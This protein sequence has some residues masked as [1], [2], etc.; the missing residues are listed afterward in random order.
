MEQ[1]FVASKPCSCCICTFLLW[2]WTWIWMKPFVCGFLGVAATKKVLTI[3]FWRGKK[4]SSCGASIRASTKAQ[5]FAWRKTIP[6][7][8]AKPNK[9]HPQQQA[10]GDKVH[11]FHSAGFTPTKTASKGWPRAWPPNSASFPASSA[12]FPANSASDFGNFY[13]RAINSGLMICF[14]NW[15]P[16]VLVLLLGFQEPFLLMTPVSPMLVCFFT[17]RRKCFNCMSTYKINCMFSKCF[18]TVTTKCLEFQDFK[19]FVLLAPKKLML[20]L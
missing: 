1:Q 12:S 11:S 10:T 7:I 19:V 8:N 6:L 20:Q 3:F 18:V 4:F 16:M 9:I 17:C 2:I 15:W 14:V 5:N 13:Q